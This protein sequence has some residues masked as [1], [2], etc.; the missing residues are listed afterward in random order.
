MPTPQRGPLRRCAVV[1]EVA[2]IATLWSGR[3]GGAGL[4]VVRRGEVLRSR[5]W[6]ARVTP[7]DP[8][9]KLGAVHKARLHADA[10][11]LRYRSTTN[12]R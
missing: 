11:H 10:A 7:N 4:D 8:R 5:M 3:L 12:G 2:L 1:D 6:A 9:N